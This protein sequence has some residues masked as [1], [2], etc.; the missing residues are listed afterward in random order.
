MCLLYIRRI[1]PVTGIVPP[2]RRRLPPATCCPC[3]LMETDPGLFDAAMR[4]GAE[5]PAGGRG[6]RPPACAMKNVSVC[7]RT[8]TSCFT[9][10]IYKWRMC[11]FVWFFFCFVLFSSPVLEVCTG[12]W[13]LLSELR[14]VES[15]WFPRHGRHSQIRAWRTQVF[16]KQRLKNQDGWN[17]DTRVYDARYS[18]SIS[19]TLS[20]FGPKVSTF[21]W[22]CFYLK[23][24]KCLFFLLLLLLVV[25]DDFSPRRHSRNFVCSVFGSKPKIFPSNVCLCPSRSYFYSK[26]SC[27]VCVFFLFFFLQVQ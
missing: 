1:G 3:E 4:R 18:S 24:L 14:A 15:G 17:A 6:S 19:K 7:S 26:P 16:I 20:S 9:T 23:N 22:I 27:F 25:K 12:F 13:R 5:P 21:V 10:F 11:A 2:T 8:N